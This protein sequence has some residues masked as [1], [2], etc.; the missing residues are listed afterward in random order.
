MEKIDFKKDQIPFTQVANEILNDPKL[1]AKAKGLY[2]YL[3]SKPDGWDFAG[4]R[5]AKDFS[6]GRLS[7][8]NGLKELEE[9][10]YLLRERQKTGRV[11]YLLKSQMSKIDIGV[12]KPKVDFRTV[13]KPHSAKTDTV[14]NKE[15]GKI[16]SGSNKEVS[17]RFSPEDMRMTELLV[18][19]ITRN[20]PD[21]KLQG[22][23]ET[24]AS[25][26]EKL[27]RIDGRTYEQIEYMIRW[28]Q[29]DSFWST[30]ILSTS[31]LR[32]KFNDLIPKL[33]ASVVKSH[34]EKARSLV[35]KML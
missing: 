5:I 23:L 10:G 25:H 32:E 6:D 9:N 8:N 12:Q 2:A 4:E 29:A 24:W 17:S 19:L 15:G 16:K 33:K 11:V 14:S 1:S 28:T 35:P 26:I 3:Y 7:I 20:N 13:Q 31:K 30:N 22:T 27:H 18:S 21:W 34:N